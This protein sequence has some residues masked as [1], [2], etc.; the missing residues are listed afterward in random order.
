MVASTFCC[1]HNRIFSKL[2]SMLFILTLKKTDM[3]NLDALLAM[4]ANWS[5]QSSS[6]TLFTMLLRL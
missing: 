2:V 6:W 5:V 3:N 4:I 1:Q